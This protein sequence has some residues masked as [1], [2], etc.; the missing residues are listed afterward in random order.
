MLRFIPRAI[1]PRFYSIGISS[2]L[3]EKSNMK[4]A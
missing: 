2:N 1:L 4:A 3:R